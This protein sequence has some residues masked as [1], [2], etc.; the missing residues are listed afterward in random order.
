MGEEAIRE[1]LRK[2]GGYR[3]TQHGRSVSYKWTPLPVAEMTDEEVRT[4]AKM[5]AFDRD[6]VT[7]E[8]V[9]ELFEQ[10]TAWEERW[11]SLSGSVAFRPQKRR[12]ADSGR[13]GSR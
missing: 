9:E 10:A 6:K 13:R 11:Q 8:E 7:D 3:R 12:S 1:I 2:W 4:V 5:I